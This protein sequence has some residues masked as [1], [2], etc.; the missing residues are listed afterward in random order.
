[1]RTLATTLLFFA[2][3]GSPALHAQIRVNPT[4]VNVNVQGATTV[5]LTF[6][7]VTGYVPA[8]SFWCGELIAAPPPALGN[9]CDPATLFG[10]LPPRYDLSRTSGTTG[11]TDIMSI[12][13]AVAR[14]AYQSAAAGATSSFFYVR[15]F[16]STSG[17]PDQYVAVTC[18]LTGGGARV[19][20]ALTNV[21]VGF[22]VETPILFVQS[23]ERLPALSADIAY[24]GTGTLRGR[25]EVVLP[26]ETPPEDFDLLTEG[27]LPA[28]LRGTQR[29]FTEIERFNVFLPPTGRFT[30]E[31]PD[32]SKIP[33]DLD[34]T[35][36]ILLRVEATDDKEGDS[37]LGAA[38]AG[39][40]VLHTGAVAGFPL[41]AL[42]Y[43]VG[44]GGSEL[45]ASV[46]NM[47]VNLTAPLDG[48]EISPGAPVRF[49]WE[50]DVRATLYRLEVESESGTEVLEAL[51][52][53]EST[54]Y[55]APAWLADRAG[56]QPVRWRVVIIDGAGSAVAR[57]DWRALRW[58]PGG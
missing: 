16:V 48:L 27:T 38:G 6:G 1:M 45:A 55:D 24:N 30:L 5:F 29:R 39:A 58:T 34:G 37:D 31:G 22:S 42:R 28:E 7:G 8:E 52:P 15:R 23:G 17:A 57:S 26:G 18:R 13:P 54:S 25:W 32:P 11:F 4:G 3:A 35:Y 9:Q 53:A 40:G 49:T 19:P 44:G 36:Q 14:R 51:L 41:P 21:T 12:P 43:Y 20:F 10:S 47:T 50:P 46:S 56:R 33:T 2:L